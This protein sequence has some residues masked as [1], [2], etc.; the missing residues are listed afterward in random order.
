[1][2]LA[3]RQITRSR[4]AKPRPSLIPFAW[5]TATWGILSGGLSGLVGGGFAAAWALAFWLAC[6]LDL[7]A[8]AKTIESALSLI[9]EDRRSQK[10][11]ALIV[12][13]TL[14]GV[15]KFACLG[16]LGISLWRA[17]L[18]PPISLLTGMATLVVVPLLGGLFWS[19]KE[20][21][22]D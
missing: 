7:F 21:Q 20:L 19:R 22:S 17:R 2:T 14:W 9:A 6:A 1:M 4:R 16:L 3:R 18:A 10:R 15:I 11:P 8:L 12:K 13:T 5:V